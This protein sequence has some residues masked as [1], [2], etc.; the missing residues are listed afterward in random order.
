MKKDTTAAEAGFDLEIEAVDVGPWKGAHELGSIRPGFNLFVGPNGAGKTTLQRMIA[1]FAK[2]KHA[3]GDLELNDEA[4]GAVGSVRLGAQKLT[5]RRGRV[6]ALTQQDGPQLAIE[7]LPEPLA[8]LEH[9]GHRKGEAPAV[10]A[11]LRGLLGWVGLESTPELVRELAGDLSGDV[12]QAAGNGD[13]IEAADAVRAEIH[14]LRRA[15]EKRRDALATQA[16]SVRRAMEELPKGSS[17]PVVED[18]GER[19]ERARAQQAA[20]RRQAEDAAAER[21]FRQRMH[22]E[23]QELS[24][25]ARTTDDETLARHK[26]DAA[27]AQ[28]QLEE[29]ERR[30]ALIA[31]EIDALQG[32]LADAKGDVGA[33]RERHSFALARVQNAEANVRAEATR[34]ARAADLSARLDGQQLIA[35]PTPEQIQEADEA[36]ARALQL[37]G[38]NES[39]RRYAALAAEAVATDAKH[40]AAVEDAR[41]LEKEAAAVWERLADIVNRELASNHVRVAVDDEGHAHV[42]VY[43]VPTILGAPSI[44]GGEWV[45]IAGD[46]LSEGQRARVVY[47]LLVERRMGERVVLIEG[48]TS[49]DEENLEIVGKLAADRNLALV[50][51]RPGAEW[52]IVHYGGAA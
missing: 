50:G 8:L 39:R 22:A 6:P 46:R 5:V 19:V 38:A 34:A 9:G 20:L 28:K 4:T 2:S 42:E 23:L 1:L 49:L 52:A 3:R 29:R 17:D 27:H 13:L 48:T 21:A 35:A 44:A 14:E 45:D 11:R 37:V 18:A 24:A 47:Q 31:A 16:A 43:V 36:V 7:G 25:S 12:I 32:K 26:D 15:A 10:R 30:V 40:D 51:E 33:W 41:A